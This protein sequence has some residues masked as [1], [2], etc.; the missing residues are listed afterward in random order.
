MADFLADTRVALDPEDPGRGAAELSP[1][2]AV[3]GPN[4]G[5]LA[6]IALRA[7]VARSRLP[8][9]ASFHGR[10]LAT[11]TSKHICRPNPRYEE[12]LALAREQGRITDA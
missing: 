10:L 8:R 12:D 1:E 2:W 7:A 6:A 9:P 3:W 5:Y 4:G 11:G